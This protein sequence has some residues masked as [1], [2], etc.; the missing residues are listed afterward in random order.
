M[1]KWCVLKWCSPPANRRAAV[2]V[3]RWWVGTGAGD[4]REV[5]ST[6]CFLQA[7]IYTALA[8]NM[9]VRSVFS[10]SKKRKSKTS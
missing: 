5:A 1:L 10:S 2:H 3:R 7:G 9:A 6:W 8:A 4:E